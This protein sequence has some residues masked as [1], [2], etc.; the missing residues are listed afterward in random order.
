MSSIAYTRPIKAD[1]HLC[2]FKE[3]TCINT[4]SL[5]PFYITF[6]ESSINLLYL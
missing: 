2:T 4:T 6:S 3:C 5:P 1:S